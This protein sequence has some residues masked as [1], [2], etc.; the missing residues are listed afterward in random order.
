M[1]EVAG[2]NPDVG[3]SWVRFLTGGHCDTLKVADNFLTPVVQ[4]VPA[5]L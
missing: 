5:I 2:S 1:L 3:K 4:R